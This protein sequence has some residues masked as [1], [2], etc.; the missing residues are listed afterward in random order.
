MAELKIEYVP[1][2]QI[3]RAEKNPKQH[4][5]DLVQ[6]SINRFG[7]VAPAIRDTRT[8]RL[9]VG[10]GRLE[11]LL[12]LQATGQTP[13]SGIHQDQNGTW[14]IP[15]IDG[16]HSRSDEEAAA[17]LVADNHHTELGGWDNESLAQLLDS[18]GDTELVNLTGWNLDDL[19]ALLDNDDE[20]P[21]N[22]DDIGGEPSAQIWGIS[23]ICRNEWEQTDLLR[24]LADDGYQVKPI[25]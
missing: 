4:R 21:N 25:T 3:V 22:D 1:I 24:R 18:I 9:V 2:D 16:W 10:H 14:L 11:A 5:T 7:Y 8:G 6:Q 19:A 13:P 12:A 15:I 17:Y 20:T 23:V